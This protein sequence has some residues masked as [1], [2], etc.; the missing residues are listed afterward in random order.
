[1]SKYNIV[2][3]SYNNQDGGKTNLLYIKE[4]TKLDKAKKKNMKTTGRKKGTVPA[5]TV[6]Y[7]INRYAYYW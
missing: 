6:R 2:N 1:M 3:G 4:R 5:K 7:F